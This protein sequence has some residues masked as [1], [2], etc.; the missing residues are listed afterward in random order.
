[1]IICPDDFVELIPQQIAEVFHFSLPA[2]QALFFRRLAKTREP[3]SV[4]PCKP[5][6]VSSK[7]PSKWWFEEPLHMFTLDP[8]HVSLQNGRVGWK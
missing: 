4:F 6:S 3:G 7:C 8:V 1:M 2:C 5:E